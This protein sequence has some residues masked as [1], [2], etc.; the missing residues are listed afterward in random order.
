MLLS[1]FQQTLSCFQ[2]PLI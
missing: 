1:V 2:A